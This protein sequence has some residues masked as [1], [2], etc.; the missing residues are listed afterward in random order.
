MHL[1]G[2][3]ADFE[4]RMPEGDNFSLYFDK[5]EIESSLKSFIEKIYSAFG[6]AAGPTGAGG[7]SLSLKWTESIHSLQEL[8]PTGIIFLPSVIKEGHS[9]QSFKNKVKT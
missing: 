8:S 5:C 4:N 6:W 7:R 9:L 3:T 1:R 2:I